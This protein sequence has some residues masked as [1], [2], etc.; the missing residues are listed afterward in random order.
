M[1]GNL[2]CY[3]RV[4]KSKKLKYIPPPQKKRQILKSG[5]YIIIQKRGI[6]DIRQQNKRQF[7]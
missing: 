7:D 5:C 3:A 4:Q 6:G 1:L 2:A